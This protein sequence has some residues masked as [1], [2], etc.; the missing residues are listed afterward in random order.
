MS[1]KFDSLAKGL[2]RAYHGYQKQCSASV[3]YMNLYLSKDNRQSYTQ[4][5]T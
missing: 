4:T 3:I 5:H 1:S 2:G